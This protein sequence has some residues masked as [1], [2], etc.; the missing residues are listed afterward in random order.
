MRGRTIPVPG[1]GDQLSVVA[2][3]EDVATMMAAAVGNDAAAGQIFN[4]GTRSRRPPSLSLFQSGGNV[5]AST[6]TR[7]DTPSPLDEWHHDIYTNR[8]IISLH[9]T[10]TD[11]IDQS[12]TAR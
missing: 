5:R 10:T 3:A 6:T 7:S 12:R 11:P 2:H 9:V 1:S 4:A 8:P